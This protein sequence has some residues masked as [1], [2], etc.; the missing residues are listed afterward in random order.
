MAPAWLALQ[1]QMI[2][3]ASRGLLLLQ[4]RNPNNYEAV[5]YWPEGSGRFAPL[6]EV[7]EAAMR[8]RRGVA[9][10]DVPGGFPDPAAP[11]QIGFPIVTDKQLQ[12]A[13]AVSLPNGGAENVRLAMRQLQ[14]GIAWIRDRLAQQRND[15]Q[16]H[17]LARARAALDLLGNALEHQRFE[18]AAMATVTALAMR[19]QC[20]RVS[21]GMLKGRS[22]AVKVIS[23]T[24]QFGQQM[25]LVSSLGAAMD[26][27]ID[28]RC[29]IVFPAPP[30][31]AIGTTAH[32]EL[33]KFQRDGHILTV[34][35]LVADGFVGAMT[36]ER[37]PDLPFEP[38]TIELIGLIAS[39]V[40]PVLEEKR[41]NDR[42]IGA[43]VASPPSAR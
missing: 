39:V 8:E 6:A 9:R 11:V 28:Q 38:E 37:P 17:L 20:T 36:F 30:D 21:L 15:Q 1:C 16:G 42:W 5:A 12:G 23:H 32:A 33:S 40:G 31:Q 24:A 26:E 25:N 7:A 29:M 34:P 18:A 27:A 19:C 10:A 2:E 4:S 35:M 3:G 41:Q 43:K 22:V 14:W 13:V